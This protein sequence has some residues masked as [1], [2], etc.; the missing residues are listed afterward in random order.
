LATLRDIDLSGGIQQYISKTFGQD[1]ADK[2]E[3]VFSLTFD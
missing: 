1:V 3:T 2:F